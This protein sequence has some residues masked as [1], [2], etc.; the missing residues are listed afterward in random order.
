MVNIWR[1]YFTLVQRRTNIWRRLDQAWKV[2][3]HSSAALGGLVLV[4]PR[5]AHSDS[6]QI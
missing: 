2:I 3:T 5:E 1:G 4:A 6:S